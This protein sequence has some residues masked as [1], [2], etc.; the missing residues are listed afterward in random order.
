MFGLLTTAP[1]HHKKRKACDVSQ[2]NDN[3]TF[4]C[5]KVLTLAFL[6][7]IAIQIGR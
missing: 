7:F 6:A 5:Q 3:P 4:R 2:Q 1:A